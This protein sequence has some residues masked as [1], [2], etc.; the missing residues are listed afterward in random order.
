MTADVLATVAHAV[1][2]RSPRG[3]AAA[4]SRLVR[5]G[6]LPAGTRLPTVRDL[7]AA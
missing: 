6:S 4:V 2:D 5:D 1:E 7:G 3:I